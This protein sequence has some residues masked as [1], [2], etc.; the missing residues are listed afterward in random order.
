MERL[1]I[2]ENKSRDFE[3]RSRSDNVEIV[4]ISGN[5]AQE[6]EKL[7]IDLFAKIG[8]NIS[9]ENISACHKVPTRR[10]DNRQP[11]IVKFTSRKF[12]EN[13]LNSRKLLSTNVNQ[14]KTPSECFS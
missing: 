12:K 14:G 11:V 9:P 8:V 10:N 2:L 6:D 7:A 1:R 13:V 5:D 4:G 3:Q